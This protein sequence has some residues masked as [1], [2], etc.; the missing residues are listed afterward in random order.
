MHSTRDFLATCLVLIAI[1][2]IL[3]YLLRHKKKPLCLSI[4]PKLNDK[5]GGV[6]NGS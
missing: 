5:K 3:Y 1:V 6:L 4:L 2:L